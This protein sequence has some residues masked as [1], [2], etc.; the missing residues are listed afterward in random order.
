MTAIV[1]QT[2]SRNTEPAPDTSGPAPII[3]SA[4]D[5]TKR[6]GALTVLDHVDFSLTAGEAVGIVGPNG[7]G[8]TTLLAV[9]AGALRPSS[10]EI[11]FRDVDVTEMPAADRCRLGIARTHQFRDRSPE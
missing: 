8:K 1:E 10:G 6:F 11:R 3:L 4:S 9:L 2:R 7:A 5:V